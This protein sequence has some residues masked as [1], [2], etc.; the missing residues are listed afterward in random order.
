MALSCTFCGAILVRVD[1][2]FCHDCGCPLL[3][4]GRYHLLTCVGSGGYGAVYKAEDTLLNR[5][6]A[7]KEMTQRKADGKAIQDFKREAQILARLDHQSLPHI[8]DYFSEA[9]RWYFVMDFIIGGTLE[10]YIDYA[11]HTYGYIPLARIVDIALQL[12]SVLDYLHTQHP[13]IIFRD[14]NPANIMMTFQ[15]HIFLIDFG[16]ARHFYPGLRY[17]EKLGTLGYAAP[18]QY[19]ARTPA[20]LLSDLYSLGVIVHQLVSG[21]DPLPASPYSFDFPSLR[22]SRPTLPLALDA[23]VMQMLQKDIHKRPGSMAEVKERLER[24]QSEIKHPPLNSL[25]SP[26][27][28]QKNQ[29]LH[30]L[31]HFLKLH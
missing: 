3:L 5:L 19:N 4:K 18:E 17:T 25:G 1:A 6:V 30:S 10:A 8:Y 27:A 29:R 14:L 24:I 23:L 2:K 21:R 22:R 12:S 13:P 16:I 26:H 28:F 15:Y 9:G 11:K 20:T 31:L 7:V